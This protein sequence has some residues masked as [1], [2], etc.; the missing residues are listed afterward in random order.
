[1]PVLTTDEHVDFVNSTLP[2]LDTG[3]FT[4]LTTDTQKFYALPMLTKKE[5]VEFQ[6]GQSIRVNAVTGNN[7]SYREVGLYAQDVYNDIDATTYGTAPW[8]HATWN[9][10]LDRVLDELN[11]GDDTR[12]LNLL[13]VKKYQAWMS[14]AE[15]LEAS[16]WS[17]P[18][19]S[20]D[21]TKFWG[22]KMWLVSNSAAGFN[23]GN[24]SGYTNGAILN[25][26]TT[27]RWKN[28]TDRYVDVST[29]DFVFRVRKACSQVSFTSPVPTGEA[30]KVGIKK[31]AYV[32][33]DTYLDLQELVR[34]NNENLGNDLAK[35]ENQATIC[36]VPFNYVPYLDSDT[37]DPCYM[38]NWETLHP[39]ALKDEFLYE[40]KAEKVPGQHRVIKVDCDLTMN[41]VCTDKRSNAIIDKA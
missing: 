7:N 3:N 18:L 19:D 13:K 20:T 39:V 9:Y 15:G 8:R 34:Q 36:N 30:R 37:T 26:T 1:M 16:W 17:K 2:Y 5:K 38:I 24:P 21:E 33:I 4:D 14:A 41:Y 11:S 28:Y 35:F 29:D 10:V 23:G 22:V 6:K 32:N 40:S 27:T 12:I 31:Q 25:A